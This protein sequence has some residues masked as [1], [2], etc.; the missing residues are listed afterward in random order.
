MR[1]PERKDKVSIVLRGEAALRL[2]ALAFAVWQANGGPSKCAAPQK[3]EA[4]VKLL[5]GIAPL[6][7]VVL[8]TCRGCE[9]VYGAPWCWDH[10]DRFFKK[11][12]R[13]E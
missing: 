10:G 12:T 13:G 2:D 6:A 9:Q 3:Q 1:E 4:I 5:L 7:P 11:T 8:S